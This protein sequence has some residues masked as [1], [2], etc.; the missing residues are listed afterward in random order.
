[1]SAVKHVGGGLFSGSVGELT[2]AWTIP[3][4]DG[5]PAGSSA[6]AERGMAPS[7]LAD[8]ALASM[9]GTATNVELLKRIQDLTERCDAEEKKNDKLEEEKAVLK[10]TAV[11]NKPL[12]TVGAKANRRLL[13]RIKSPISNNN[14]IIAGNDAVHNGDILASVALYRQGMIRDHRLFELAYD[15]SIE[16]LSWRQR[17]YQSGLVEK[18]SFQNTH[19]EH[20]CHNEGTGVVLE[21]D[22][23]SGDRRRF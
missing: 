20:D 13:E 21:Q 11:L 5:N 7:N 2:V 18:I 3:G 10:A 16:E 1:M 17:S 8:S 4:Y 23:D 9:S 22:C 12:V 6:P 14:A 15:V 19:F